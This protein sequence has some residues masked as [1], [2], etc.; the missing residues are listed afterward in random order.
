MLINVA[1]WRPDILEEHAEEL[2]VLW[3]RRLRAERSA[4]VDAV[5]LRRLDRRIEAHTDALVLADGHALRFVERLLASGDAA[6]AAA[7]AFVVGCSDASAL[8]ERLLGLLPGSSAEVRGAM[9]AALQHRAGPALLAGLATLPVAEE[10]LRAGV[11]AVCAVH[12]PERALALRPEVLLGAASPIARAL[13]WHAAARLGAL[14]LPPPAYARVFEDEVPAVRRAALEAAAH[15]RHAP[16]L[17]L[18]RRVAGN[19]DRQRLEEHLLLAVLADA[20]DA[21]RLEALSG[22]P[23]LGWDRYRLLALWG[24]AQAVPA[25]LEVMRGSDVV[26]SAL[27]GAAFYRITGVSTASAQRVPLVP[28]G[29]EPDDFSDLIHVCDAERAERAWSELRAR[30]GDARWAGGTDTDA[31]TPEALPAVVDLESR[32]AAELRA[33]FASAPWTGR[34]TYDTFWGMARD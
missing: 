26:E 4:M 1:E 22:A 12:D 16:L 3:N 5:G 25:L 7:G 13:A 31:S 33:R 20:S 29:A 18:L 10:E 24:R 32:W 9:W 15:A 17:E 23:A 28:A 30:M 14:R 19:P 2:D 34:S 21:P 8:V 27:A 11:L 6:G